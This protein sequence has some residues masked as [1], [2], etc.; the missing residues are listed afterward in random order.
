MFFEMTKKR[1]TSECALSER[2]GLLRVRACGNQ[3]TANKT[4][5]G[6]ENVAGFY[7]WKHAV[8]A[9]HCRNHLAQ[10]TESEVNLGIIFIVT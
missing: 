9:K 2:R 3:Q 6:S 1:V 5:A 10:Q 8:R 4:G 7:R